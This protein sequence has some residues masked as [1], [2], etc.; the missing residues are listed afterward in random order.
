MTSMTAAALAVDWAEV[1]HAPQV[2]LPCQLCCDVIAAALLP[3]PLLTHPPA[4]GSWLKPP[5][6]AGLACR[7]PHAT[8]AAQSPSHPPCATA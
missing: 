1:L 8:A 4:A 6:F 7:C 3:Q 5:Q 2:R